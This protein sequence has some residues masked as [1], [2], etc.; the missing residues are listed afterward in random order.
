[1]NEKVVARIDL[2]PVART[3][4]GGRGAL[5]DQQRP[6]ERA[7]GPQIGAVVDRYV[8]PAVRRIDPDLAPLARLRRRG[9]RG[10]RGR[11]RPVEAAAADDAQRGDVDAAA[12]LDVAEQALMLRFEGLAGGARRRSRCR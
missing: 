5:L 7:A 1:M 4:E 11:R 3:D 6:V 10:A 9:L 8:A 12:R 2:E